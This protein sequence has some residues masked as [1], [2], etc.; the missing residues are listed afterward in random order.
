MLLI[1][2]VSPT[3]GYDTSTTLLDWQGEHGLLVKFVRWDAIYFTQIAQWG[4]V[5][6]QQWAWGVGFPNILR[7]T[8]RGRSEKTGRKRV[9][10]QVQYC[11]HPVSRS[12]GR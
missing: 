3:P 7:W 5:H 11:L 2:L 1:V 6:E 8:S 9:A 10:D 4:R 12:C